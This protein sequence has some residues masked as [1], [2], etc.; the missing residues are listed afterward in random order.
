MGRVTDNHPQG[1]AT[2]EQLKEYALNNYTQVQNQK[3][4]FPT[5]Q[6]PLPSKGTVYPEGNPLA[7][8]NVEMK[9][10]TAREEDILTSQNLIKQGIVLDKV[11]QSMIVSPINYNDLIIGDKNSIMIASRILGYG[12]DYETTYTCPSCGHKHKLLID[13]TKMPEKNIP[14]DVKS[15]GIN[16]FE[17]TLPTCKRVVTFKF[18]SHGDEKAI[19]AELEILKKNAKKDSVDRELSTRL[20]YT[21]QSVDGNTE[22]KFID[23][24]VDN[25]LLAK[26]SKELRKYIK[27]ASP[28]QKFQ[29]KFVC[30][31]PDCDYEQ[32]ALVFSIDTTFFWPNT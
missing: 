7:S 11:M 5:E 4:N 32:E 28:D 30:G 24:F 31:Q 9:Y 16:R 29:T 23:E 21:I 12:K 13:L 15:V 17:F 19:T 14:E 20:K 8:G 10:M 2:D 25:Q 1:Q 18:L 26:D 27:Y 6:V 3:G 22:E